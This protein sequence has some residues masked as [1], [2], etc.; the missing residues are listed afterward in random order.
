MLKIAITVAKD[1]L[2]TLIAAARGQASRIVRKT[3][4]D[5]ERDAKQTAP[6]DT[7]KLRGSIQTSFSD[8]LHA[9]VGTNTEYAAYV[10]Y[11]TS[12]MN[13][14][15]YMTPAAERNRAA[16]EAAFKQLLS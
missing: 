16:F 7:G 3:A 4:L 15:P 13:A 6:V 11:G 12:R 1:N 8:D 10:E 14:Q 5:I 2:P 9:E